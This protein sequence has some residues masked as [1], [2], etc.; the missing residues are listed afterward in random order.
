M[1]CETEIL[2]LLQKLSELF[3]AHPLSSQAVAIYVQ[4]LAEIPAPV[5]ERALRAHIRVCR[6]FPTVAELYQRAGEI[7][8]AD[9]PI[10][11]G[12]EAWAEVQAEIQRVGS[13]GQP[14][15][16]NPLA[17]QVVEQPGWNTLCLSENPVA[18]SAHFIQAY[19]ALVARAKPHAGL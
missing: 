11:S 13:W 16:D 8:Q 9:H 12:Y 4:E 14:Q 7:Q 19:Q 18:D 5:L 1:A 6:F 17:A 2:K 10:P 3:P 15:L